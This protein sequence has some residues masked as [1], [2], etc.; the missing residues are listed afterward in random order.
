[1]GYTLFGSTTFTVSSSHA[2]HVTSLLQ[3]SGRNEYWVLLKVASKDDV[4][5]GLLFV[6]ASELAAGT[7]R[8]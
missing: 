6:E 7:T 1:M 2:E 3:I 5:M 8:W 4:L